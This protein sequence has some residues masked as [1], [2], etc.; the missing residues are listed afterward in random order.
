MLFSCQMIFKPFSKSPIDERD[1]QNIRNRN[2]EGDD[3]ETSSPDAF[4]R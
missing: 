4:V 3:R 1:Y 2:Q